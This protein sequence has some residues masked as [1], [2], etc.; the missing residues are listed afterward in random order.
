MFEDPFAPFPLLLA[1]GALLL[2]IRASSQA[3]ELR[4]RLNSLEAMLQAQRP[5]QPP[6]MPFQAPAQQQVP[7]PRS[8][9]TS[10]GD[11]AGRT[12]APAGDRTGYTAA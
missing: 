2:A 9:R 6:P 8:G 3:S 7:R 11:G 5:I 1:I 4:R 10:T 12:G